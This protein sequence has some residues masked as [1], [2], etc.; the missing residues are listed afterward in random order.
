[1]AQLRQQV[2]TDFTPYRMDGATLD[3]HM[4]WAHPLSAGDERNLSRLRRHPALADMVPLIHHMLLR[5]LKLEQEA[6][7]CD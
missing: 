5:G 3:A 4:R 1:M 7:S 2:S 6:V